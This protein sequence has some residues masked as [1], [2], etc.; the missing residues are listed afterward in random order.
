MAF[1]PGYRLSFRG[2][3]PALD[4]NTG[5]TVWKTYTDRCLSPA[6]F[7]RLVGISAGIRRHTSGPGRAT[8]GPLVCARV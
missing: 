6:T 2:S 8:W 1:V 4:L 5:A 7:V 3:M